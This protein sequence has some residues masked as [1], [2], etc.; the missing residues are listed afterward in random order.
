MEKPF[1]GLGGLWHAGD[2]R[3]ALAR[4]VAA[5]AARAGAPSQGQDRRTPGPKPKWDRFGVTAEVAWRDADQRARGEPWTRKQPADEVKKV[6]NDWSQVV[7]QD[8]TAEEVAD[9]IIRAR[10]RRNGAAGKGRNS[11]LR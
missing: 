7:P 2:V 9:G 8:P 6:A 4:E 10:E 1:V 3:A 5:A 11:K